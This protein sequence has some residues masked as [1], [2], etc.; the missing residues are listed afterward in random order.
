MAPTAQLSSQNPWPGLSAF[1]E[2]DREFFFGRERE[3]AQ[4]VELVRQAPAGVLYGQSG[5]GK[6]SLVQ[7]GLFPQLKQLDFLPFRVRFDHSDDAPSLAQQI[8]NELTAEL[9][10][11]G[12]EGP[13]PAPAETLWEY[14]YRRDLDF[15]GSG[16]RLLTPV[17]V[18][19][20]FEEVFTLGQRSDR[21]AARVAQFAADLE[22][23]L[24]H[25]A[26]KAVR[27]RLEKNPEE[28]PHFDFRRQGVKFLL[29]LREDFLGYLDAWCERMPSL[30]SI[31]NRFRLEAMTEAQA[32]EVVKR[33]GRDLVDDGV[34][35]GIVEFVSDLRHRVAPALLSVVLDELNHRRVE[36]GQSRI[37]AEFL[38]VERGKIIQDFYDRSFE[39]IDPRVR[40]WAEDRLLTGSGH[41]QSAA[42]EDALSEGMSGAELD[43]LVDRR[44]LRRAERE[45]VVW[46]E[47][48]HDLLTEPASR[49]RAE[50]EQREQAEEA[51]RQKE[52]Y[53]RELKKSRALAGVF[54]VLLIG[55]AVALVIAIQK[56]RLA[57][58]S[59][60]ERESI[61]GSEVG[62]V[63]KLSVGI[64]STSWVPFA[65]VNQTIK[66]TESSF[67]DLETHAAGSKSSER[68]VKIQEIL[69][70][71]GAADALYQ[72]GHID[73]GL[74]Q[75]PPAFS[76]LQGIGTTR[77]SDDELKLANAE[78]LYERGEGLRETEK[79]DAA[80]SDFNEAL[81]LVPSSPNSDSAQEAAR[82]FILSQIGLGEVDS[83]R[84]LADQSL[85]H[86]Q[87]ALDRANQTAADSGE[88][89]FLKVQA[90][91]ELGSKQWIPAQ[92]QIYYAQAQKIIQNPPGSDASNARWKA[93][94]AQLAFEQG[95][96]ATDPD[97]AIASLQQAVASFEDLTG[98]DPGNW[99]WQLMLA[100]SR[101]ALASES[102]SLKEW[103]LAQSL[104]TPAEAAAVQLNDAQPS[105]FTA[106][107]LRGST[108]YVSAEIPALRLLESWNRP[109]AARQEMLSSQA[110]YYAHEL[111]TSYQAFAEAGTILKKLQ[112]S[113]LRD[114]K[115]A[116]V[117]VDEGLVRYLDTIF[118]QTRSQ[119]WDKEAFADYSQGVVMLKNIEPASHPSRVFL[120]E[121]VYA[122]EGLADIQE[123]LKKTKDAIDSHEK[124]IQALQEIVA[125]APIAGSY[126][127]LS[128]QFVSLGDIYNGMKDYTQ[129]RSQYDQ[130]MSAIDMAIANVPPATRP[131]G[132]ACLPYCSQKSEVYGKLSAVSLARGDVSGALEELGEAVKVPLQALPADY[133]NMTYLGDFQDYRTS[134][135]KIR[136]ALM[137]PSSPAPYKGLAPEQSKTLLAQANSLL[138]EIPS[139]LPSYPGGVWELP[140]LLPGAWRTLAPDGNE[141][142]EAASQLS[143]QHKN[144]T[145][146][147]HGIRSLTLDFY[148]DAHLYEAEVDGADGVHGTLA[149]VQNGKDWVFLDGTSSPIEKLNRRS[150]PRL[151]TLERAVA[152]LRFYVGAV[153]NIGKPN[154][155]TSDQ[156]T[157]K[158]GDQ[159]GDQNEDL[160]DFRKQD[161]GTYLLVDRSADIPWLESATPQQRADIAAKIKPL[162]VTDTP[163]HEWQALGTVERGG[164]LFEASYRLSRTGVV[165]ESNASKIDSGLP[166]LIQY[167]SAGDLRVQGTMPDL[168]REAL[169]RDP[170]D[171]TAI[172]GLVQIYSSAKET[173]NAEN[174]LL[175]ALKR[176][177]DNKAYITELVEIYI[178]DDEYTKTENLVLDALKRDTSDDTAVNALVEDSSSAAQRD[179]A[180]NVLLDAAKR[181]PAN[182]AVLKGLMTLYLGGKEY[183]RAE[184]L[185]LD[186]SKQNP[187]DGSAVAALTD[188]SGS[189]DQTGAAETVLLGALKQN[190]ADDTVRGGLI[191]V[192]ESGKEYDKADGLVLDA[193]KR[194]PSDDALL[195][196]LAE[197][198]VDDDAYD[199]ATTLMLDVL[200]LYP[201]NKTALH[202]LPRIYFEAKEWNDAVHAEE[203]WI[204]YVKGNVKD[205]ADQKSDLTSAYSTLSCDQ[206]LAR[207]FAGALDSAN[208]GQQIDSTDPYL[209][210]YRADALLF[211]GRIHEADAI[212]L[213]NRGREMMGNELGGQ[214]WASFVLDEFDELEHDG[215]TSPEIA[216]VRKQ[217][218]AHAK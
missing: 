78:I 171:K 62:T 166:V 31:S 56:T 183:D 30:L 122:Y 9:D 167:F 191:E 149:C 5:L 90:L 176:H 68:S 160:A 213:G 79:L 112:P 181:Y 178:S 209:A 197:K 187:D 169:K 164:T 192:Y 50:R 196:Q 125:S 195:Q 64:G 212:Y 97:Q 136:D 69:F 86:F 172:D 153:Q 14:F 85:D 189:G 121:E 134:I 156:D 110:P 182:E 4:L 202:F 200:K 67:Q 184:K 143:A 140:P 215:L 145:D 148:D 138:A 42:L 80:T 173:D 168:L 217:L 91:L 32:L 20:Q 211:L 105:W 96:S 162:W 57:R 175:A 60:T 44:I 117:L 81:S 16:N 49:S 218:S 52:Q 66:S 59:E 103:D 128:V 190:P 177:P 74:N 36:G 163:D 185:L 154:D 89:A 27:Q 21:A 108:V 201:A 126:N 158:P 100:W 193:L 116:G 102:F 207:D 47:L 95:D 84:F 88:A 101:Q 71:A 58:R 98:R 54:G 22:S 53:R 55:A 129:A 179:A 25:R 111:E 65:T 28:A 131:P 3:T 13:R 29:S 174:L 204:A 133:T 198:Y 45:G 33:G 155:Q 203:N 151:D 118:D 87:K 39:N 109:E 41:R 139:G 157:A 113:A 188:V 186:V 146:E 115:I 1:T 11:A 123:D 76:L 99:R 104:L 206:L 170:D 194:D 161:E 23:V 18:L 199:P 205:P 51:I 216:K 48:T 107:L 19:D 210:V 141:Y 106:G 61:Y 124:C 70:R 37:T 165:D 75:L 2:I 130:A 6:T 114:L 94:S 40:V 119:Q 132:P 135:G 159:S 82:I 17:I 120:N 35:R 15:W 10:R 83:D 12:V 8:K 73:D 38:S 127:T 77:A 208:T 152:Y 147:L 43:L 46:L 180:E 63:E 92:S 72:A 214:S 34:A 142:K 26:P 93:Q 150:A 137:D 24:E 7:A 144:L